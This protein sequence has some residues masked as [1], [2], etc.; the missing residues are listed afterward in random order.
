MDIDSIL[1]S[2]QNIAIT[3]GIFF[4][5]FGVLERATPCN[6]GQRFWRKGWFVDLCYAFLI[7]LVN[8][9]MM[10]ALLIVGGFFVF[11]GN[12]PHEIDEYL[13][14]GYGPLSELPVWAQSAIIVLVSDVMLYWIHR[15]FHTRRWWRFHAIHHSPEELNWLSTYRFHFINT[16]CAFVLVDATMILAGFSPAA[17]TLMATVNGLYSAMVHANLNWT[18]GKFGCLFASPVF[19]RWHHTSQEEGMDKNFAPTFPLLDIIFGTYYMPEGRMPEHFGVHGSKVPENFVDQ[20]FWPF[21][22]KY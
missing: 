17:V 20:Q 18:F 10:I 3:L 11:Y 12:S 7:P 6:P 1:L 19:H 15:I 5:L 9:V 4:I 16:W 13:Q 2:W 22:Q 8:R 21:K 14:H